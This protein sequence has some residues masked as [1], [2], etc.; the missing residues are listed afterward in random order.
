MTPNEWM[1][2]MVGDVGWADADVD[3]LR[4]MEVAAEPV[5][6]GEIFRWQGESG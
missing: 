1:P 4:E 5:S 2:A 3:S 6:P